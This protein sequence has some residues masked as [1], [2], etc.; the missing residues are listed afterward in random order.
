MDYHKVTIGE[1]QAL[2]RVDDTIRRLVI[3]LEHRLTFIDYQVIKDD[4]QKME[5]EA[6][7]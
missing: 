5:T 4:D 2:A 3:G 7:G 1:L 6:E